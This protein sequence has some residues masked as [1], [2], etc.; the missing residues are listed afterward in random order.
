MYGDFF[1]PWW[2][3]CC[4]TFWLCNMGESVMPCLDW[5]TNLIKIL[6]LFINSK[7]YFFNALSYKMFWP[8]KQTCLNVFIKYLFFYFLLSFIMNLSFKVNC[9]INVYFN[10]ITL[11]FFSQMFSFIY[12]IFLK[13]IKGLQMQTSM[14][15]NLYVKCIFLV[16]C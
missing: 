10:N 12:L 4:W 14:F 11:L 2:L 16:L 5:N 13:P 1:F 9:L 6:V 3:S 8:I 15:S 7:Y